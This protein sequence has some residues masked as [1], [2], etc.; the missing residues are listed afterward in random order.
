MKGDKGKKSPDTSFKKNLPFILVATVLLT[1]AAILVY[2]QV[3]K[4]KEEKEEKDP[5]AG[6]TFPP[7][8]TPVTDGFCT[9][10]NRLA[11]SPD[12]T[13]A[14][15]NLVPNG[16]YSQIQL[17]LAEWG[18]TSFADGQVSFRFTDPFRIIYDI[19][20][21]KFVR[22]LKIYQNF[23]GNPTKTFLDIVE[24]PFSG[25]Y[26]LISRVYSTTKDQADNVIATSI[27]L[28]EYGDARFVR[29]TPDALFRTGCVTFGGS[30]AG[31]QIETEN[32]VDY[33]QTTVNCDINWQNG[34]E[35][36]FA[37]LTLSPPTNLSV[38]TDDNGGG[39]SS[40]Y[41]TSFI[42]T[43]EPFSR[44]DMNILAGLHSVDKGVPPENF[45][46]V[47]HDLEAWTTGFGK[48]APTDPKF[49]YFYYLQ[50]ATQ[51][52]AN[53]ASTMTQFDDIPNYPN[54]GSGKI[55]ISWPRGVF[56]NGQCPASKSC[57]I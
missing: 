46:F 20:D 3:N 52:V 24:R 44:R 35:Q 45:A 38:E 37:P 51:V 34:S 17:E 23:S 48:A 27:E 57:T 11:T 25:E 28:N 42:S 18:T 47:M 30:G 12:L 43:T 55:V 36:V 14:T 32:Q 41:G 13:T 39:Q 26:S 21:E 16:F 56:S 9:E 29:I 2:I 1:G 19:P 8:P 33:C 50:G 53:D 54:S 31:I 40:Q 22:V 7:E 6:L 10:R 49:K 15:I 4:K 5:T